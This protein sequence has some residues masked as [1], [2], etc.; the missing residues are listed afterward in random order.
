MVPLVTIV[1]RSRA[2]GRELV[3]RPRAAQRGQDVELPRLD[4][5]R[6]ERR[7][8]RQVEQPGQPG[9]PAEHLDGGEVEVGA[10]AVPRLD[11]LV[12]LVPGWLVTHGRKSRPT[13]FLISRYSGGMT[14]HRWDPERYLA[15][16]DERGRPFVEL[17]ARVAAEA[18]RS[19]VDLGCGAGNLTVLLTQ[20]WPD[21]HVVGV[22][23]S[24][25]MVAKARE[26]AGVEFVVGG[27]A[28]LGTGRAGRRGGLQRHLPVDPGPPRPAPASGRHRRSRRLVRVRGARQLRRAQPHRPTRPGRGGAVR[29]VHRGCGQ[30]GRPRRPYLPRGARRARAARWTRGRRRTCT[31]SPA[32]TPSS[33]GSAAP[34][35]GRRVQALPEALRPGFEAELKRRLRAVVPGSR[36]PGD[37]AVPAGL[38]GRENP[39][40]TLAFFTRDPEDPETLLPADLARSLWG[41]D[42]MHGVALSGMLARALER[43]VADL[44]RDD[45]RAARYTVDLFKAARMQPCRT[46]DAGGPRGQADLPGRRDGRAGRRARGARE[47]ALPQ[48]QRAGA[49]HRVGARRLPAATAVGRGAAD[50]RPARAAVRQRRR[51]L[52]G[53]VR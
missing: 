25:E 15:Y 28:R 18:P 47:R 50:R 3:R 29:R 4:R 5:L 23:S 37:P 51:R 34:A 42:Q 1:C 32:R 35:C 44:G 17:L 7:P 36:R 21:A 52:V 8:P 26:Q 41:T 53:L 24:P 11:E 46:H 40:M 39:R 13:R 30:P 48:G 31:C 27:R 33:P 16:A 22:D 43:T 12:D 14:T 38:R 49:G 10:L 45:L 6:A 9:D 2:P 19:V 20:R